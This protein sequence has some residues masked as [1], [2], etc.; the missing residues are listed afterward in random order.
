MEEQLYKALK[1]A[2]EHL[3][4]CGYGDSWERSV[5][6]AAGLEKEIDEALE[7]YESKRKS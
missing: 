6:E 4:Y 2:A 5:A 3:N 7:A 1:A